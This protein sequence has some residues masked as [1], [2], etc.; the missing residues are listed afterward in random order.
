MPVWHW[1]SQQRSKSFN[2][3]HISKQFLLSNSVAETGD[4]EM[5]KTPYLFF[6]QS[7]INKEDMYVTKLI[8]CGRK[9]G[10]IEI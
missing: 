9:Y 10:K 7:I 4:T 6:K 8:K 2:S 1:S 3:P 5:I